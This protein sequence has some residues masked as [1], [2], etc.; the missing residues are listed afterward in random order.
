MQFSWYV[1][2]YA[3]AG[4]GCGYSASVRPATPITANPS[5][6]SFVP[7]PVLRRGSV[8]VTIQSDRQISA[9]NSQQQ[10]I[11]P[12][13]GLEGATTVRQPGSGQCLAVWLDC[14]GCR[15]DARLFAVV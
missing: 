7:L 6:S 14:I 2:C 3:V 10:V 5:K 8:Q 1:G 13:G 9:K 12:R 15:L 11:V 4:L